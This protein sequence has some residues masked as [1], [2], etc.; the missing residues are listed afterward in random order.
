MIMM[1]VG[2]DNR[3]GGSRDQNSEQAPCQAALGRWVKEGE[4]LL[5]FLKRRYDAM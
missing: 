4:E 3:S 2:K 1:A 5:I